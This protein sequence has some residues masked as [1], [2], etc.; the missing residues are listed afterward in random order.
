MV[1]PRARRGERSRRRRA[2]VPSSP[3][4]RCA[5]FPMDASRDTVAAP[6]RAAPSRPSRR[7]ERSIRPPFPIAPAHRFAEAV[8]VIRPIAFGGFGRHGFLQF[9]CPPAETKGVVGPVTGSGR[10]SFSKPLLKNFL[11]GLR[12]GSLGR[13]GTGIFGHRVQGPQLAAKGPDRSDK[14][15]DVHAV[16]LARSGTP[17]PIHCRNRI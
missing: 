10:L 16:T 6:F 14:P 1:P 8:G 13:R 7:R 17:P 15:V 2:T 5:L 3:A 9:P 11:Q 12:I 4:D